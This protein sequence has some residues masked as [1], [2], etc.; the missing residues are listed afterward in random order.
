MN[1]R[2]THTGPKHLHILYKYIFIKIQCIQHECM[3]NP[4]TAPNPHKP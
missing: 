1:A 2:L 4:H 3:T